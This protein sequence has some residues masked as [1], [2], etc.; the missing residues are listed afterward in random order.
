[1][2][3]ILLIQEN[4]SSLI[5]LAMVLRSQGWTVLETENQTQAIQACLE[6]NGAINLLLTDFELRTD[7]GPEVA[8]RLLELSPEM[9]VIFVLNSP[10]ERLLDTESLPGDYVFL[11]KPFHADTLIN[12]LEI[13]S[14][15]PRASR[16]IQ[17]KTH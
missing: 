2:K 6:N 7:Y 15:P 3:T 9:R 17:G 16:V 11:S 1:L 5:A 4:P 12:A 10:L 14:S 8:K 13:L